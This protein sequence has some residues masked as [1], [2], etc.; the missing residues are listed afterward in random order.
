M[1]SPVVGRF[2]ILRTPCIWLFYCP[3]D[4]LYLCSWFIFLR[5]PCIWLVSCPE[6]TLY[7]FIVLRTP[8]IWL[9]YC[10]EHTLYLG[11]WFVLRTPCICSFYFPED[12]LY[13]VDLLSYGHPVSGWFIARC[14]GYVSMATETPLSDQNNQFEGTRL[15]EKVY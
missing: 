1:P 15:R 4:T 2:I 6:D 3:E 7:L 5:T 13:L 14:R 10:P 11:S 9:V 12:T 8:C